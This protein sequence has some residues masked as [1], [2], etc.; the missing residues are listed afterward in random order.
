MGE[1]TMSHGSFVWYELMTTDTEAAKAFYGSVIGWEAQ[2]ADQPS[3]EY[4]MLKAGGVPVAGLMTLTEEARKMGGRPGWV[5]YVAVDD[6]DAATATVTRS[7]GQIYMPKM[8][9]PNVGQFA[10]CAD[11]QGAVFSPFHYTG[12]DAG[13]PE[14]NARPGN[15]HF[16]WDE[17]LT[18]DP[19]AAE[20]FY[21]TLFG[22]RAE[23]VEMP[24]MRYTLFKRPG[25]KDEMGADKNAAGVMKLPPGVPRSFW[26]TYVAVESAD[27]T[28]E[29]ATRLGATIT[30][31][32]MDIPNVGRFATMLDAQHAPVAVLQPLPPTR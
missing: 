5:G 15:Y 12:K 18:A 28:A 16:C 7:G 29:K 9:I 22:W 10:I 13:K 17:L 2:S 25:V 30:T 31:P 11:A 19:D 6:V 8:D 21:G 32:P 3:M 23:H 24:G 26:M 4:T 20:R 1:T 27:K 14:T